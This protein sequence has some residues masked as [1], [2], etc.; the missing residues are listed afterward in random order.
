MSKPNQDNMTGMGYYFSSVI[1]YWKVMLKIILN[2]IEWSEI[3]V[4]ELLD[5]IN[6]NDPPLILDIRA[7]Q[8]FNGNDG[9]I[10]NARSIAISQIKPILEALQQF[11]ER[12]IVTVCP[13]GGL[14]LAAANIL[15]KADFK[16]VKSLHGGMDL[17]VKKGY[18]TEQSNTK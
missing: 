5:R 16:D 9:H 7:I 6:S 17:W 18:P 2:R 11:K 15:E 10:P 4:D 14:S 3:T 12:E 1:R 13:G 8:H